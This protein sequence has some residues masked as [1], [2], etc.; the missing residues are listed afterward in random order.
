MCWTKTKILK[1]SLKNNGDENEKPTNVCLFCRKIFKC[2]Y[3]LLQHIKFVHK[4][5]QKKEHNKNAI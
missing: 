1:S 4:N 5:D 3:G 2:Q